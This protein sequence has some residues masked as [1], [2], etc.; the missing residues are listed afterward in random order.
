[1]PTLTVRTNLKLSQLPADF[2]VSLSRLAADVLDKPESVTIT[3]FFFLLLLYVLRF[4]VIRYFDHHCASGTCAWH[5][6]TPFQKLINRFFFFCCCGADFSVDL[7]W[8]EVSLLTTRW[9]HGNGDLV[10]SQ[11][12]P[13]SSLIYRF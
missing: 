1:M 7:E 6:D 4:V 11:S 3:E 2:A 5:A 12:N 9:T 8:L 13:F 10:S